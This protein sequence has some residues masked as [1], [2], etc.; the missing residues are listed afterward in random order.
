M[1]TRGTVHLKLIGQTNNPQLSQVRLLVQMKL[2]SIST[3][4]RRGLDCQV[5]S[6]QIY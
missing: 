5:I 4:Q 2:Y 1:G 3:E 6:Q